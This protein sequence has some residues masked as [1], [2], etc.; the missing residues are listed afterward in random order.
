MPALGLNFGLKF[1]KPTWG[2]IHFASKLAFKCNFGSTLVEVRK[3][4]TALLAKPQF[5]LSYN[6]SLSWQALTFGEIKLFCRQRFFA[7]FFVNLCKVQGFFCKF[8]TKLE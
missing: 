8:T 3:G 7:P 5:S 6:L 4:T 2:M 1:N